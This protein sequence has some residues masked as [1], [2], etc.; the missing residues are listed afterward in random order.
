MHKTPA[1]DRLAAGGA[2]A[3][4]AAILAGLFLVPFAGRQTGMSPQAIEEWSEALI[5]LLPPLLLIP[6]VV[7]VYRRLRP[8][9]PGLALAGLLVG[10]LA[11]VGQLAWLMLA[12]TVLRPFQASYMQVFYLQV[13]AGG[14]W[15]LLTAPA[16]IL[17]GRGRQTA[18]AWLAALLGLVCGGGMLLYGAGLAGGAGALA[19]PGLL[20]WLATY[21]LWLL[22]LAGWLWGGGAKA[23]PAAAGL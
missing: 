3:A 18:V 16:L 6:A 17:G 19:A 10:L 5:F 14:L 9:V 23:R 21:P 12:A 4:A 8:A 13:A 1:L 15:V 2:G 11:S 7:I 22:A 20:L